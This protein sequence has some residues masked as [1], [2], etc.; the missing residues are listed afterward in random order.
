MELTSALWIDPLKLL[1]PWPDEQSRLGVTIRPF[2]STVCII[3]CFQ[4]YFK[5]IILLIQNLFKVWFYLLGTTAAFVFTT[6]A[7]IKNRN[8]ID[9]DASVY[10]TVRETVFNQLEYVFRIITNQGKI[11]I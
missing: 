9:D 8:K 4:L 6:A 5:Y 3:Y 2:Q 1:Q 11:L 7:L 10:H